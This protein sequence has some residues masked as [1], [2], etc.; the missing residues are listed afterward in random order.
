MLLTVN[1]IT[2]LLYFLLLNI[3]G[4]TKAIIQQKYNK[5][6]RLQKINP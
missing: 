5:Y 4:L 1:I 3:T 6:A 2:V